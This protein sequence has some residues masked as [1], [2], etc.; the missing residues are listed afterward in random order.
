MK[1]MPN[2]FQREIL[3]T[4][5]YYHIRQ[6]QELRLH[7]LSQFFFAIQSHNYLLNVY[8]DMKEH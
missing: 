3:A 5:L 2:R 6:L 4:L 1:K 8:L 7:Y